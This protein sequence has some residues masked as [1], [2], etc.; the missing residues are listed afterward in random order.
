MV[1]WCSFLRYKKEESIPKKGANATMKRPDVFGPLDLPI[2]TQR[3][4]G[5]RAEPVSSWRK[6]SGVAALSVAVHALGG[7]ALPTIS[8]PHTSAYT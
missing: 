6:K 4:V 8:S 1:G 5:N 2:I 3:G 7:V